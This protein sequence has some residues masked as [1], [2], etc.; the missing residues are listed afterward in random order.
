[1]LKPVV[2]VYNKTESLIVSQR[3][4]MNSSNICETPP[5]DGMHSMISVSLLATQNADALGWRLHAD[6]ANAVVDFSGMRLRM[7]LLGNQGAEG[8]GDGAEHGGEEETSVRLTVTGGAV[9]QPVETES[10]STR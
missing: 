8:A 6:P 5:C 7:E 9:E 2:V 10:V 1:M 3:S 4:T